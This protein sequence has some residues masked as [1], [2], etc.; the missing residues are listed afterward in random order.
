MCEHQRNDEVFLV[1][2]MAHDAAAQE[3]VSFDV[4]IGGTS[5]AVDRAIALKR[6]KKCVQRLDDREP[7]LVQKFVV[8]CEH[9]EASVQSGIGG[10]KGREI[11]KVF[12]LVVAV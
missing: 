12:N 7:A 2:E 3:I 11:M 4:G 5:L 1:I 10:A 9:V 6:R 8:A